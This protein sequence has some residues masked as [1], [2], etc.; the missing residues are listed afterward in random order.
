MIRKLI[1]I[2]L[3][4]VL[5]GCSDDGMSNSERESSVTNYE[6]DL[7]G[8]YASTYVP[9]SSENIVIRNATIFDGNGNKFNNYDLHFSNGEIQALGS[10]LIVENAVEIDGSGK[11]ITPGI[12]DNHSHMGVYPAPGVRTSSDGNE[13]T[14]PVTAEVWAEHSVWSQ[15]PQ[16]KLAL[17]G[18][19]TTF[20]VLPG[21]ANL[22]GGRGVTLKNVSANTVPDMKFPNAPHSLK[23]AC[24]E[25]PKR[26]YSSSGPST[27]MGNVA[28]YRN[29]WIGAEEYRKSLEENPNQRDLRNETLVGVLDGKILV[30]NHCYRADEMATMINISEEFGY[31]VSTFHHGVEAYKIADL[32]ADE[33]ICAALWADWWGFKHEAYD[34]SIANIAIVDQAR[35][36]TGCAIVH[37]DSASGIQRLNQEAAKALAAGR[38]AGFDITEGR[39]MMWI[40]KNPAKSL[41][42]L[43]QTGTLEQ[44]KDADVVI[45]DGNP[46]S[47]YTKAERVY[48]DGALAFD[49]ASNFMPHTDFDLGIKEWEDK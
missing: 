15:D 46:F 16:Y 22:F 13:A 2:L 43:D 49:K 7:H 14:N 12:I 47:V 37:S 18:G 48:I 6:E 31:K 42:I 30:H 3:A 11:F 35:G 34:M 24:G 1:V 29:A 27:R 9:L 21:S 40:T 4:L 32:L 26:V 19:V 33:G 23:M 8:T 44:G 38:R 28:G 36:G 39:A 5:Y 45:W 41:G 25:N 10:K 20:H 17:A